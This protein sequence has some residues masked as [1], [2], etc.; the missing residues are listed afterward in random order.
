MGGLG[1]CTNAI[2]SA[3]LNINIVAFSGQ[4]PFPLWERAGDRAFE[5][6]HR[7]YYNAFS[8]FGKIQV[9][10]TPEGQE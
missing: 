9:I 7:H 3:F 4:T 1:A 2:V 10:L 5:T 8:Y 6:S